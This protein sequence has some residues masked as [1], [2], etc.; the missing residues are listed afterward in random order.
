MGSQKSPAK[1]VL[2]ERAKHPSSALLE[3]EFDLA[4]RFDFKFTKVLTSE[5]LRSF[6]LELADLSPDQRA[7]LSPMGQFYQGLSYF[8]IISQRQSVSFVAC[9][10]ASFVV[11]LEMR[12]LKFSIET[13]IIKISRDLP[14]LLPQV[15]KA[16][17][18]MLHKGPELTE[19]PIYLQRFAEL[20]S[21]E[22]EGYLS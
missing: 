1:R 19:C 18:L 5:E 12:D 3:F 22:L 14:Y 7:V 17:H 10:A 2:Q 20:R 8:T 13:F 15:R 21:V 11:M 6:F 9:C 4:F 16:R